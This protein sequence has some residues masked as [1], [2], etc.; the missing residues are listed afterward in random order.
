MKVRKSIKVFVVIAVGVML[1]LALFLAWDFGGA[2]SGRSFSI[3]GIVKR[4]QL[5]FSPEYHRT[6]RTLRYSAELGSYKAKV[7]ELEADSSDAEVLLG[8]HVLRSLQFH[9][10]PNDQTLKK[11]RTGWPR[12]MPALAETAW[13][14]SERAT[15]RDAK[16]SL[17]DRLASRTASGHGATLNDW[18]LDYFMLEKDDP[19]VQIVNWHDMPDP[20]GPLFLLTDMPTAR[21]KVAERIDKEASAAMVRLE[22]LAGQDP[23]NSLYDYLL[24]EGSFYLG[25][26][27]EGTGH[28]KA[29]VGKKV[30]LYEV[31][32]AA[33]L[34]KFMEQVKLPGH[35]REFLSG[36]E[37]ETTHG[38]RKAL[39]D[40][41]RQQAAE[42]RNRG[43]AEGAKAIEDAAANLAPVA[44]S[45]Q[46]T[47]K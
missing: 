28:I 27:D 30:D 42:A 4:A 43:D 39:A 45:A 26:T 44:S 40:S 31:E 32:R 12:F 16:L 5:F 6:M 10:D 33:C 46:S 22:Q 7:N 35:L 9:M 18:L 17:F 3:T 2:P 29:G 34:S 19:F 11:I 13:D 41:L 36:L 20:N 21:K 38:R 24:V 23:N 15:C 37:R 1:A 47:S 25:R 14:E 8:I